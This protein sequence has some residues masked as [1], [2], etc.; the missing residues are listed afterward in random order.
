MTAKAGT[1][2]VS[3][4]L[5]YAE[6]LSADEQETE[7]WREWFRAHPETLDV[8]ME[9]AMQHDV[10]GV[11][12]HI[13]VVELRYGERLLEQPET[14]NDALSKQTVDEVFGI[15]A[16][17]RKKFRDFMA[18]ASD[19]D[20]NKTISFKTL[21]AGTISASKRKCFVHALLHGMRHWA[22]LAT[23]LRQQGTKAEWHH[24]F[25]FT[26]AMQ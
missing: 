22:Q 8:K 19:A 6:M 17:A 26:K 4:A 16:A 9:L 12:F 14:P 18:R 2:T 23:A 20:W 3:A 13:F 1:V 15:G 7:Q 5:T 24:D 11:L 10:R 21:S 25:M